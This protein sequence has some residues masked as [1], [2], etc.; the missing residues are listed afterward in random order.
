MN[1]LSNNTNNDK[2]NKLIESLDVM[3]KDFFSKPEV[4]EV[5]KECSNSF[6]LTKDEVNTIIDKKLKP[7]IELIKKTIN[8]L[9][10]LIKENNDE[11]SKVQSKF[12][13]LNS[14]EKE[15]E[16]GNIIERLDD[17]LS[18][19][20][21][22]NKERLMWSESLCNMKRN[23]TLLFSGDYK[24]NITDEQKNLCSLIKKTR[25]SKELV[26]LFLNDIKSNPEIMDELNKL[27]KEEIIKLSFRTSILY[28]KSEFEI[29]SASILCSKVDILNALYLLIKDSITK[30]E[31]LIS[32]SKEIKEHLDGLNLND[33]K[34]FFKESLELAEF[35]TETIHKVEDVVENPIGVQDDEFKEIVQLRTLLEDMAYKGILK[36]L[37]FEINNFLDD[38]AKLYEEEKQKN[39]KFMLEVGLSKGNFTNKAMLLNNI[40]FHKVPKDKDDI[41]FL[42]DSILILYF[43]IRTLSIESIFPFT[44]YT[45]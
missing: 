19:Q 9:D 38:S 40:I 25:T 3:F 37:S 24:R 43:Y 26:K 15:M 2:L 44:L 23:K 8:N 27:S 12:G 29:T 36:D 32:I 28:A 18:K 1:Q 39:K 10:D 17:C 31:E 20:N 21:K 22:L 34:F 13:G 45:I 5:Y 33:C 16:N 41:E 6:I 14:M 11:I 4:K 35:I 7:E 30:N 42:T